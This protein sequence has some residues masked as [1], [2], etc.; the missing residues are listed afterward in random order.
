MQSEKLQIFMNYMLANNWF[1]GY[2]WK[3]DNSIISKLIISKPACWGVPIMEFKSWQVFNVKK[4]V[5]DPG[6]NL[7][8]FCLEHFSTYLDHEVQ[9][10]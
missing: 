5:N 9:R 7:P 6:A 10:I 4:M 2:V 1:I 3:L 8:L